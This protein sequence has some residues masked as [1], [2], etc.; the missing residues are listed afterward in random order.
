MPKPY[1]DQLRTLQ[2]S[3]PPF[4]DA[5]AKRIVAEQLGPETA[6][7]LSLSDRPLASASLG[8]VYRGSLDGSDV[9]VKVQRPG[10]LAAIS[11]DIVI[12]RLFA[13][14]LYAPWSA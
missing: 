9:A 3:V 4:N 14:T 7:N 12:I 1:I 6:R 2:D 8:Q 10:A 11:L 5:A 13:P